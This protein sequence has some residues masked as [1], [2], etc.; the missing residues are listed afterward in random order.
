MSVLAWCGEHGVS[1]PSFYVWRQKLAQRDMRRALRRKSL[2]PIEI[3]PPA[4]D[5]SHAPLEIELPSRAKVR[6]GPGCE[7]ELLRQ[8]L[9]ILWQDLGG[10]EGC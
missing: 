7:L 2:L 1:A 10:A 3:F 8:V 4:V 9:T 6:V 5:E